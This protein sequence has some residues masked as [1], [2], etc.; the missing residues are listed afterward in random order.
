M[1][2]QIANKGTAERKAGRGMAKSERKQAQERDVA[3]EKL[4]AMFKAMGDPTRLRIF[5]FLRANSGG[6]VA[7]SKKGDVRL[8]SEGGESADGITVGEVGFHVTGGSKD[9]STV[10]HHLKELRQASLISMERHGKNM[11]C[12]LHTDALAT[13]RDFCCLDEAPKIE[14]KTNESKIEKTAS[15]EK[16]EIKPEIKP[17][18]RRRRVK[19]SEITGREEMAGMTGREEITELAATDAAPSE[20]EMPP[21]GEVPLPPRNAV[22][23]SA[24]PRKKKKKE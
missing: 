13:L 17:S 20:V 9:P 21:N 23:D 8:L 12:A 4:A 19:E 22:P 1:L 10:S 24:T 5:E 11:I 14:S 6:P 15:Q 16:P 3:T 2:T 18:L 7:L